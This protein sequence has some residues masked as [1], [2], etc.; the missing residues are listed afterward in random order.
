[1]RLSTRSRYGLRAMIAIA[2]RRG[3]HVTG[4]ALARETGIS[5]KYLDSILHR[6]REAGFLSASRGAKGG[7]A[8]A[9]PAEEMSAA[10]LVGTLE[11]IALVPCVT[12]PDRCKRSGTCPTLVVWRAASEAVR[13]VLSNLT[14][15]ALAR[16]DPAKEPMYFI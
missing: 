10:D 16:N 5:K 2:R 12:R 11:E 7:Y 8:L 6:L 14:L 15:S 4:G 13:S 3:E 1:M 9:R